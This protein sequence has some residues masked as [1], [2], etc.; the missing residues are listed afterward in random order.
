VKGRHKTSAMDRI[1]RWH[2]AQ[3]AEQIARTIEATAAG[4]GGLCTDPYCP[5][6][7]RHEQAR[8]DA[9]TAR[10]IGAGTDGAPGTQPA[11]SR[12][13]AATRRSA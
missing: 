4:P 8:Q 12:N 11:C 1:L 10:R 2:G 3:V 7:Q 9:A 5:D 6:F 13:F